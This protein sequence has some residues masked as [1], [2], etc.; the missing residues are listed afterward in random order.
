MRALGDDAPFRTVGMDS[1]SLTPFGAT[2]TGFLSFFLGLGETWDPAVWGQGAWDHPVWASG[3]W[4]GMS[5]LGLGLVFLSPSLGTCRRGPRVWD[6]GE[7]GVPHV[8]DRG[9]EAPLLKNVRRGTLHMGTWGEDVP[10]GPGGG[11]VPRFGGTESGPSPCGA[12]A[13]R[14]GLPTFDVGGDAV[15]PFRGAG[16]PQTRG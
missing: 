11:E 10:F 12:G 4:E 3:S 8:W 5:R 13:L 16:G 14:E 15:P 7:M 1:P 6:R 9:D 2:G